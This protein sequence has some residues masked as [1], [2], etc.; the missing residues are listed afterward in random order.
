MAAAVN[1][2]EE[3][4]PKK[5]VLLENLQASSCLCQRGGR[6]DNPGSKYILFL[7]SPSPCPRQSQLNSLRLE[8][9]C[10]PAETSLSAFVQTPRRAPKPG[11]MSCSCAVMVHSRNQPLLTCPAMTE[12]TSKARGT[13]APA[14]QWTV[15]KDSWFSRNRSWLP[16]GWWFTHAP[17]GTMKFAISSPQS[18]SAALWTNCLWF[19]VDR[20]TALTWDFALVVLF[21][22]DKCESLLQSVTFCLKAAKFPNL[23]SL[24]SMRSQDEKPFKQS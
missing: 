1:L 17:C 22:F 2:G 10:S 20:K 23:E 5:L 13:Q 8:P 21:L 19:L 18:T 16:G 24:I 7:P 12:P 9:G 4:S 11:A 3:F 14:V 6:P 15:P